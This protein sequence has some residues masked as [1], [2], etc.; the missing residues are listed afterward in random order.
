[1]GSICRQL[2][3]IHYQISNHHLTAVSMRNASSLLFEMRSGR[4]G[5]VKLDSQKEFDKILERTGSMGLV[6]EDSPDG[7]EEVSVVTKVEDIDKEVVYQLVYAADEAEGYDD[8]NEMYD[9]ADES[10]MSEEQMNQK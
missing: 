8:Q 9:D 6:A 1:M 5:S 7:E 10:Q 2:K 4:V 3:P